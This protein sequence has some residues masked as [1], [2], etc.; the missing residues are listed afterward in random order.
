ML[1]LWFCVCEGPSVGPLHCLDMAFSM[2]MVLL[3]FLGVHFLWNCPVQPS[4]GRAEAVI[5]LWTL[6]SWSCSLWSRSRTLW[7]RLWSVVTIVVSVVT[8]VVCG[9]N[10][11]MWSLLSQLWSMVRIVATVVTSVVSVVTIVVTIMDCGHDRG[12]FWANFLEIFSVVNN[13]SVEF[14]LVYDNHGWC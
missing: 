3:S 8:I 6:W 4:C 9:H 11:G 7:S 14:K 12:H 1:Q 10:R 5:I 13:T 2:F